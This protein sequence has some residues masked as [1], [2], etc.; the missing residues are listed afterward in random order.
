LV[1]LVCNRMAAKDRDAVVQ[2]MVVGQVVFGQLLLSLRRLGH[3]HHS[4]LRFPDNQ[5]DSLP[6]RGIGLLCGPG[7]RSIRPTSRRNGIVFEMACL[8]LLTRLKET[9]IAE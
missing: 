6:R 7:W 9:A 1:T 4:A 8:Y 5:P 3:E 2:H